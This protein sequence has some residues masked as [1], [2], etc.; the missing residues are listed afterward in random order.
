MDR[1]KVLVFE[2]YPFFS[3]AQRVSA[4]FCKVLKDNNIHVTLLL[5][6]DSKNILSE[7][8]GPVVDEIILLN[9]SSKLTQYG[10]AE[11]WF[12]PAN[13]FGSVIMGLIPFYL[14]CI[15]V[16]RKNKFDSFYFCD[17]R[18]AVMMAPSM[19]F[20]G[21][22]ICYLQGKN[23]LSERLAKMIY[24]SYTDYL[25]CPSTD[26]LESL[27]DSPKKMVLNYGIDFSQYKDIDP[28]PVRNEIEQM[29]RQ[30]ENGDRTKLLYAGLIRPQK[31]VH[32]LVTAIKD[33]K[34]NIS[35]TEM[36]VLFILGN[37]KN[38]AEDGFKKYLE[39]FIEKNELTKYIYWL[40][41]KDNVLEWM[42][43]AD[44]FIFPTIDKEECNFEGFDKV[45]ESSEGSPVVLIESSLSGLYTLASKVTGVNETITN[46]RNGLMYDP[47]LP[48]DLSDN[49]IKIMKNKPRFIDFPNSERFSPKTFASKIMSIIN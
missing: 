37:P 27:P 25:L 10:N 6:D 42:K 15:K 49:L 19:F 34:D 29:L 18:G 9:T 14:Q 32:H 35:E 11:R 33:L 8:F 21:K 48:N 36:P 24:L 31:G 39:T 44:Y 4:N 22:K 23:K 1:K 43:N 30:E 3:G 45:I 28:L 46:G 2:S 16:F 12:K 17:P 26:V 20:K 38:E 41:W 13:F 5:A 40:G 47:N 7:K